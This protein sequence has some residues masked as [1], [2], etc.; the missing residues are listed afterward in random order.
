MFCGGIWTIDCLGIKKYCYQYYRVRTIPQ[1]QAI[2]SQPSVVPSSRERHIARISR[3]RHGSQPPKS[4]SFRATPSNTPIA[5]ASR[6]VAFMD[7]NNTQLGV[8][9]QLRS[10]RI[11]RLTCGTG[12]TVK[13]FAQFDIS[14]K[15]NKWVAMN[16]EIPAFITTT[17]LSAKPPARSIE[18]T[19]YEWLKQALR[20]HIPRLCSK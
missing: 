16:S 8:S 19:R 2:F 15:A 13:R 11:K 18:V 3:T 5:S 9:G 20:T 17:P 10:N 7:H 14:D 6:I 4:L 1:S 12:K